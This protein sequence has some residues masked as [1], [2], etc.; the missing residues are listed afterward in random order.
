MKCDLPPK[1]PT[2]KFCYRAFVARQR[3]DMRV[4]RQGPI[5]RASSGR[6]TMRTATT[7]M[8]AGER[9]QALPYQELCL[10]RA[11]AFTAKVLARLF[12]GGRARQRRG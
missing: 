9:A 12:T 5:D 6:T 1:V 7:K 2:E 11:G 4:L 10:P 8:T 3:A